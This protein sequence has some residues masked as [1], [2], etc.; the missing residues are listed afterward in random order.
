MDKELL[1]TS[2]ALSLFI[3]CPRMAGI[4]SIVCKY[5]QLPLLKTSFIASIM[6]IPLILLM[7]W[8]FAKF[9]LTGALL[10]CILTDLGCAFIL[11]EINL[12]ASIDTI[13]IAVFVF[14]AVKVAPVISNAIIKK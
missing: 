1:I 8:V 14:V 5:S 4:I 11:K 9:G 2:I 12:K 10:F 6:A 13:V 7:V 3:I